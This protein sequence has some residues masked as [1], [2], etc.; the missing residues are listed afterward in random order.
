[1]R[2]ELGKFI[3][4]TEDVVHAPDDPMFFTLRDDEYCVAFAFERMTL[5]VRHIIYPKQICYFRT[6][7]RRLTTIMWIHTFKEELWLY[8]QLKTGALENGR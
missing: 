2:L 4:V 6:R 5:Y 3:R 1:M 7:R 8:R